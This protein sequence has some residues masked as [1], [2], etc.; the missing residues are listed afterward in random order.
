MFPSSDTR[1]GIAY[2]KTQWLLN[3]SNILYYCTI[4]DADPSE[5]LSSAISY[6]D[7]SINISA[8]E[9][10]GSCGNSKWT[11]ATR[12]NTC[13]SGTAPEIEGSWNVSFIFIGVRLSGRITNIN[14]FS[15][16]QYNNSLVPPFNI[17]CV[18]NQEDFFVYVDRIN[19][20]KIEWV[21]SG[22]NFY[23]CRINGGDPSDSLD[24]AIFY[25]NINTN[26]NALEQEGSCGAGTWTK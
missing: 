18:S 6:T 20:Y 24:S 23:Y 8:P 26:I 25:T 4:N 1:M 15:A 14:T 21:F 3:D 2:Y 5:S 17:P 11:K 22:S 10:E 16:S 7:P 9:Q 12:L 19:Y 13:S